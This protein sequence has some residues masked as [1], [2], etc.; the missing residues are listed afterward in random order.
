MIIW[1]GFGIMVVVLAVIGVM[2]GSLG[3][4]PLGMLVAAALTYGMHRLI[5]AKQPPRVLVDQ[6]TGQEVIL[7]PKHDLFFVPVKYWSYVFVA[8]GVLFFFQK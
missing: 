1:R 3:S 7:K 4:L 6:Q 2:V 5:E 8:L